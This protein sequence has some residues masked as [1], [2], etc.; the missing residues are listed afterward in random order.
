M[1]IKELLR[2]QVLVPISNDN[3]MKFMKDSSAHIININRVLKNIKSKVIADFIQSNQA[4]I[5]I[6]TNKVAAP[7]NIQTIEQY[8][9]NM[10]YIK[11]D[12]VE[13]PYLPQSTKN[14]RHSL[15]T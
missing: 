8:I 5:I 4:G 11:I 1:T 14:H 9:K 15:S 6:A 3:K 2:K 7:L 12:N 10:N 13:V